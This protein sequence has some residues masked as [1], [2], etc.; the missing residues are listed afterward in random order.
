MFCASEQFAYYDRG[1][2]I[3]NSTGLWPS[4][5]QIHEIF[6]GRTATERI[7]REFKAN[8]HRLW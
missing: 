2:A 7:G 6:Q 8:G 4:G 3:C 1:A 5:D